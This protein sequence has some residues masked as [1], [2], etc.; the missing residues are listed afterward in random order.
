MDKLT[1]C[2]KAAAMGV[3]FISFSSAGTE[4]RTSI[5]L[6][7]FIIPGIFANALYQGM[8]VPVFIKYSG[9]AENKKSQQ[10]IADAAIAIDANGLFIREVTLADL[11]N[12]TELSPATKSIITGLKDKHFTEGATLRLG[13]D[14]TLRLDIKSFYLEL[15]VNQQALA[16]SIIPRSNLLGESTST[17]LSSVLN[18]TVGSYY[19]TYSNRNNGSSFITLDSTTSL[20]ESH[21]NLNGSLYGLGTG[22]TSSNLYRAM[23]ERDYE[24]RRLALGMVD[25]WNLQSIAS[26]SA[27]NSSRIYGLSYGNKSSTQIEDNTL[28]LTPI[29][30]FLPSAGEVHVYREGRLLSIQNFAMGS[31]EIDTS[32]LPFGVYNVDVQ[33]VVNGKQV[34]SRIA[35]INKTFSRK[36]SLT[37]QVEWQVFSGMLQYHRMDYRR[38]I[39][40][41]LGKKET[42]LAG[43]A[44]ALTLPYLS[45]VSLK[46][47][48][49]GFDHTGVNESEANVSLND[50][51]SFNQQFMAATDSSWKSISTL[52]LSI[53][54]GYGSLWGSREF[55]RIGDNLPIEKG[56]FYSVGA[57]LNLRKM[58]PY[59]G[60]LS[61]SRTVNHYTGNQ[62]T[63]A[64]YSQTLYNTRYATISVRAGIQRYYYNNSNDDG[65]QDK[66]VNIELS[67][68]L[69]TWLSAG[70]SSENGNMLANASIRKR[71]DDSVIT[72]AGAS[73]SKRIKGGGDDNSYTADE[74]SL[75]GFASYDTKYNAGTV[76]V[77]HT[78]ENSTNLSLSSQGS[79]AWS[80]CDVALSKD[81]Q[82]SGVL[83]NTGFAEKGTVA[84]QVN[85][86]TY[87]L[88]GKSNFIALPP[89]AK[90][91]VELMNDKNSEDSVDIVSGRK[92]SVVLYPGNVSVVNPEIKQLVTVFGRIRH[93]D[94]ALAVNTDI[95]NHIGKTQTDENGEF[96]MD[97][98]KKF[99][100]ITLREKNGGVCEAELNL[101][102]ARGAVW[103]GD[104]LCAR[105]NQTARQEEKESEHVY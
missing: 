73:L 8:S 11:P 92:N 2:I 103:L 3:L 22:D 102:G 50:A 75:N 56:D 60:S 14:A 36:S 37:G 7:E 31:Y 88:S 64:D 70:V 29:T 46:S 86:R 90:Y 57:T 24:G 96:A 47:T 100:F 43:G 38:T 27:L 44:A 77:T 20:R 26:M 94:G 65:L 101:Q 53:P 39:E 99:P 45:G 51:V 23:Y 61:L 18:Y 84:A 49:Y 66:Y 67:M 13:E 81:S 16:A 62:Y 69:A 15:M 63:N 5:R 78:S 87:A 12:N 28:S 1:G 105:Q 42:W 40:R 72:N 55:S 58:T 25:T 34:S 104:I 48:L 98:D 68:P 89:Y 91:N 10:K 71:F 30:V 17:N 85:G 32:R 6:G 52:N 41:N 9:D 97:V 59:L 33:V 74:Y 76:A 21:V 79:V 80:G 93:A 82:R 54:D 83:V 4:K 95:H 35:Q 19:N